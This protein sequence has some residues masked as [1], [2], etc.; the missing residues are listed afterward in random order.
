MLTFYQLSI[1]GQPKFLPPKINVYGFIEHIA[2][3]RA[4][5]L[6]PE[7]FGELVLEFAEKAGLKPRDWGMNLDALRWLYKVTPQ[8]ERAARSVREHGW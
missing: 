1:L 8:L 3:T 4:E 5:L 2:Q 7:N 6:T